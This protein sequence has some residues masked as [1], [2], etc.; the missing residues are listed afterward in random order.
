[1]FFCFGIID[2]VLK[3]IDEARGMEL[4]YLLKR[5]RVQCRENEI[6]TTI[7]TTPNTHQLQ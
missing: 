1:M 2:N 5:Q 3:G 4:C 6:T 7:I